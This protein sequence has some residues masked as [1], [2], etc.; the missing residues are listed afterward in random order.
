VKVFPSLVDRPLYLVGARHGST[1][2]VS[3]LQLAMEVLPLTNIHQTHLAK[4]YFSLSNPPAKMRKLVFL[5][6]NF[7]VLGGLSTAPIVCKLFLSS[8]ILLLLNIFF[9]SVLLKHYR[10]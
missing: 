1:L 8:T 6:P 7:D 5:D 2:V 4:E 3:G 9:S 10:N